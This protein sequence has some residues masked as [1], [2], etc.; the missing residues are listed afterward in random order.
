MI[1]C[2]LRRDAS[3]V[4][5]DDTL[6]RCQA[7]AR[8]GEFVCPVQALERSEKFVGIRHIKSYAVVAHEHGART[9]VFPRAY[10]DACA[11]TGTGE[12]PGVVHQI[13]E[14]DVEQMRV[15]LDDYPLRDGKLHL[16]FRL[17]G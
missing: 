7:D 3:T 13:F 11:R 15:A 10:F 8:A 9:I 2:R 12:F 4:T 5:G 14:R 1:H 16:P 6:N 17:A